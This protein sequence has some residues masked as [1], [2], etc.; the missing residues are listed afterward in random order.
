M[1]APWDMEFPWSPN[2]RKLKTW[3]VAYL[4]T[5]SAGFSLLA[6]GETIGLAPVLLSLFPYV[7]A[8]VFAYQVQQA[9]N[10]AKLYKPARGRSLRAGCCSIRS[11]WDL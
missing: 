10:V 4:L 8:L 1:T 3:F 2:K 6:A 5:L 11:F 7:V 9:L